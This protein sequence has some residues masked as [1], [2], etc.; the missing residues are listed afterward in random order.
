MET[1]NQPSR[2]ERL[3]SAFVSWFGSDKEPRSMAEEMLAEI[4]KNPGQVLVT[5]DIDPI[6]DVDPDG[7]ARM[8][9]A[10]TPIGLRDE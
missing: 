10:A 4:R 7:I 2:Y 8:L 9:R 6:D 1:A 3:R 5:G